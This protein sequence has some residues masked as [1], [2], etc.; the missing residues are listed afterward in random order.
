[1]KTYKPNPLVFEKLRSIPGDQKWIISSLNYD[2]IGANK[3]GFKTV[4]CSDLELLPDVVPTPD[5][6]VKNLR[7]AAEILTSRTY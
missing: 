5:L 4:F 2:F 1:M 6:E 3:Y 7:N